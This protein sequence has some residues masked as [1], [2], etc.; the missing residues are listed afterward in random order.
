[1]PV[2]RPS[3]RA[4]EVAKEE[5]HNASVGRSRLSEIDVS[6]IPTI[7]PSELYVVKHVLCLYIIRS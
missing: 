5:L 2:E 4:K 3:R 1:M 7:D 6:G